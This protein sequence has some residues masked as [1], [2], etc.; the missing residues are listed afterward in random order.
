MQLCNVTINNKR[1]MLALKTIVRCISIT[2][3]MSKCA[4]WAIIPLWQFTI[5]AVIAIL[6]YNGYRLAHSVIQN[7]LAFP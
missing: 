3:S 7:S 5:G 4:I 1:S 2:N 6:L